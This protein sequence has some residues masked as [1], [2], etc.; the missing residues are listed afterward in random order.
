MGLYNFKKLISKYSKGIVVALIETDG[1]Y[2]M[3][4]S[5]KWQE[6]A[7]KELRLIPAAIVPI[8]KDDLKFDDG[9]HY[10][11]DNRKLYCYQALEKGT[12][13]NNIQSKGIVKSYKILAEKDYSDYDDDLHIYILERGDRDDKKVT[14][15]LYK[16]IEQRN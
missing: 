12:I 4:N 3:E 15:N 6:G 1:Y 13:I 2:D 9:G 16:G 5:G 11:Y 10:S 14:W 7:K 8:N